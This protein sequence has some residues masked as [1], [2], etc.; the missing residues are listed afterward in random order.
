MKMMGAKD[1]SELG[2]RFVS[3]PRFSF[4]QKLCPGQ[5]TLT[6]GSSP[7]INSRMVERDIFD[8]GAGL[9]RSGLW[10]SRAAKL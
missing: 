6:F 9:D 2:P 3:A 1:I 7:Q 4:P 8:G 10:T 5:P